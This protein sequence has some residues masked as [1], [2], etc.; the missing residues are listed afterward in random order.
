MAI[1]TVS[2]RPE[3]GVVE[4]LLMLFVRLSLEQIPIR[5]DSG[6]QAA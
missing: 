3:R 5:P 1:F 6:A 4:L 2:F